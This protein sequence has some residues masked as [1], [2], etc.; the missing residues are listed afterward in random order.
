LNTHNELNTLLYANEH[1][2]DH[3]LVIGT[4]RSIQSIGDVS[5][6]F[7]IKLSIID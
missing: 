5:H 4:I 3:Q 7:Y 6:N 2:I 1:H